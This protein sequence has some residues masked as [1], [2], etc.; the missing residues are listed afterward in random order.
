M[1]SGPIHLNT[2]IHNIISLLRRY[3]DG[4]SFENIKKLLKIDISSS[5]ELLVR[6]KNNPRIEFAED[7]VRYR[8]HYN[9]KT[10]KDLL[11]HLQKGIANPGLLISEVKESFKN[12]EGELSDSSLA[13]QL[14]QISSADDTIIYYNPMPHIRA[15]PT[16]VRAMWNANNPSSISFND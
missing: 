16:E 6:L 8:P 15:A 13:F 1:S 3:D 4:L 5:P 12:I 2:L 10:T 7:R 9:I 14:Y 11:E